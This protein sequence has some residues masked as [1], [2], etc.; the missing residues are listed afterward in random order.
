MK[1]TVLVAIALVS[2]PMLLVAAPATADETSS[3]ADA[4]E[5]YK[6]GEYKKVV[7]LAAKVSAQADD[8][9]RAR[10]LLGEAH[11]KLGD[12]AKAESAFAAVLEARP[13]AAP[14]MVGLGKALEGQGKDEEAEKQYRA[15]IKADRRSAAARLALGELQMRQG[16]LGKARS[17]LKAAYKL[18]PEDARCARALVEVL[19][20]GGDVAG[21]DKVAKKLVSAKRAHPMGYFLCGLT[22]ERRGNLEEAIEF[23]GEALAV[24]AKFLDAHKNLAILYHTNNPDYADRARLEAA[25]EHYEQY[26]VLGGKDEALKATWRRLQRFVYLEFEDDEEEEDEEDGEEE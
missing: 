25:L 16:A 9:P 13:K 18:T 1:Y 22:Q 7:D 19:L 17:T 11:L 5:A 12:H 3:L 8:Y 4:L 6:K 10:Y 14:A 15:A 26:F 23:Y 24:D 20:R 2:V 21:A